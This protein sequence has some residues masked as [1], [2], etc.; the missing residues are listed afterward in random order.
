VTCL[1]EAAVEVI[2]PRFSDDEEKMKETGKEEPQGRQA[3][4]TEREDHKVE[5]QENKE[6]EPVE[7]T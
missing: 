6:E 5:R 4:R 3:T 7:K 2:P 1:L